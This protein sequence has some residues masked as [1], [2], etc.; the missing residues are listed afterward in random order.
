[1]R[2]NNFISIFQDKRNNSIRAECRYDEK[3]ITVL[4]DYVTKDPY[5]NNLG[6]YNL[7][8]NRFIT[9]F[10]LYN[11]IYIDTNYFVTC[12]CDDYITDY[13]LLSYSENGLNEFFTWFK[14]S[15]ILYA[16]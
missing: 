3:L 13:E 4:H 16:V 7:D 10:Y 15:N 14:N 1:M 9:F 12:N 6:L 8:K 2:Y 11:K 5:R